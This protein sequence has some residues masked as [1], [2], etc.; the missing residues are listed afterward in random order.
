MLQ[1]QFADHRLKLTGADLG[2]PAL[3]DVAA[4]QRD[5]CVQPLAEQLRV[6]DEEG[7][8]LQQQ[9]HP[10]VLGELQVQAGAGAHRLDQ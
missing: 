10:L 6:A 3:D 2:L 9:L 7:V 8:I 5:Q 1:Q 4:T